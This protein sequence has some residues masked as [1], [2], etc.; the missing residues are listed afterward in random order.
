MGSRYKRYHG[1][2][3]PSLAA[4]QRIRPLL[5]SALAAVLLVALASPSF[6]TV[7]ENEVEDVTTTTVEAPV[8][9]DGEPAIVIPPIEEAEEEQPWTARFIYPTIVIG[10]LLLIVGLIWAYNRRIRHRYVVQD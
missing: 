10:T 6:A 4:M 7:D 5:V 1:A 2:D 3:T 8:F 9:E